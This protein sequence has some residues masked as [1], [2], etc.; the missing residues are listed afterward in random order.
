MFVGVGT[1]RY[2]ADV[3]LVGL[4]HL[5][6]VHGVGVVGGGVG[7]VGLGRVVSS[8]VGVGRLEQITDNSL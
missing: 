8:D 3:V 2:L 4:V 6:A 1:L 7:G 5:Q